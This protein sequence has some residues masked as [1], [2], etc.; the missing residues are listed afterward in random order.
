M[1]QS[2]VA[3]LSQGGLA[4]STAGE[5]FKFAA[6][7]ALL[8]GQW[9]CELPRTG[10]VGRFLAAAEKSPFTSMST[11]IKSA[12]NDAV[13]P[14]IGTAAAPARSRIIV[15]SLESLIIGEK[16]ADKPVRFAYK[17]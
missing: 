16:C 1:I 10:C 5:A 15:K 8:S 2:K 14:C 12:S 3:G 9:P 17:P 11:M 7:G 13:A 6:G 4:R